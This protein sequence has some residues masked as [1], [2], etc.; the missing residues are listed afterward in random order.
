[1]GASAAAEAREWIVE[2]PAFACFRPDAVPSRPSV[3]RPLLTR[4]MQETQP[5]I[6]RVLRGLYCR[7]PPPVHPLYGSPIRDPALLAQAYLPRG[8]GLAGS[9]ALAATGWSTQVPTIST[10][11]VPRRP[12]RSLD[13]GKGSRFIVR[14][15]PR[16]LRLTWHEVT[17][18]EG[19]LAFAWCDIPGGWPEATRRLAGRFLQEG[20]NPLVRREA[21]LWAAET[22]KTDRDPLVERGAYTHFDSV[23]A[24]LERDLP[25]VLAGGSE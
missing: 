18:L 16:R 1:M 8:S 15:N 7:E 25:P 17:L 2:L 6:G 24:R 11:A 23:L 5:I 22:E 19:C 4:M 14:T 13:S 20:H 21:L 9:A 3:V 12:L 10:F